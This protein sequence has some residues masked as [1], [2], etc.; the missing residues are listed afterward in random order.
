MSPNDETLS[1]PA[2]GSLKPAARPRPFLL[3]VMEMEHPLARPGLCGLDAL[4]EVLLGRGATRVWSRQSHEGRRQLVLQ[5]PDRWMSREHARLVRAGEQWMLEDVNSKNGLRVN[6]ET[7]GRGWLA[8]GDL[9]ELGHTLLMFRL[10]ASTEPAFSPEASGGEPQEPVPGFATMNPGLTQELAKLARVARTPVPVMVEGETGT[11]KELLARAYHALSGRPGDFVAVNCG[12]LP[13]TLVQSELFGY[14]KGAF[15]GATEDRPGL[16]RSSDRGTL[17]LDEIGELPLPAQASLLRVLQESEVLP[18]GGTRPLAVDL[19]VVAATNRDLGRMVREGTFRSDLL[20]RLSGLRLWI[21]PLRER[22]EDVGLLVAE[23]LR[24]LVP[25]GARGPSFTPAAAR[26]LFRYDWPRNV[27]ELEHALALAVALSPERI[28]LEHLPA[29]LQVKPPPRAPE[30]APA[31]PP[32][33][34]R[35]RDELL[36]LLRE[37]QGNVSQIAQAL[38]TSRAQVHRLFKRHGLEPESFRS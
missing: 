6:G 7:R 13:D 22:R 10:T 27:R 15:S 20:A 16:V 32:S 36:A 1:N 17:F 30:A 2:S 9:L 31:E 26:A 18:V 4:D 25:A 8:N 37:H 11:G 38:G 23:L 33:D 35:E 21:P 3:V 12:A 14:R 28:D 19:R 34:S 24:R 5:L 29:E